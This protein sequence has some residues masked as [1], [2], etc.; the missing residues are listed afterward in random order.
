VLASA[1]VLLVGYAP[2]PVSWHAHLPGKVADTLRVICD[3][4]DESLVTAWAGQP[5]QP[6]QPERGHPKGG[7][8]P[9]RSRLRR[10]SSRAL[11]D[12]RVEY[13]RTMSE[14]A[15][16]ARR[17][18]VLWPAVV[19]LE[20]LMDAVTAAVVAISRGAPAP[21]PEAVHQLTGELRAVAEAMTAGLVL[22]P[23][24][25]PLPA[26]EAL[27]PVT[28]AVRSVLCVLTPAERQPEAA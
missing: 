21:A 16:V 23:T 20:D 24:S 4:M 3:Y 13:Q 17:A 1:V 9:W 8:P 12:L 5:P 26:D 27:E 25:R 14:P 2:W 15:A 11:S 28:A 18:S 6:P 19:A 10:R 22:P 7:Q